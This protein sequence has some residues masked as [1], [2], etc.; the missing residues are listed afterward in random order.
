MGKRKAGNLKIIRAD[1]LI[2]CMRTNQRAHTVLY[3][4]YSN[5]QSGLYETQQLYSWSICRQMPAPLRLMT[6]CVYAIN[7]NRLQRS[8]YEFRR[9][10]VFV[11]SMVWFQNQVG[12]KGKQLD[13]HGLHKY[14]WHMCITFTCKGWKDES[15]CML[16]P[17]WWDNIES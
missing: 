12:I 2:R 13:I 7:I 1:P 5:R 8:L 3:V 14:K 10:K 15:G 6:Y 17:S 16:S 4:L 9:L 11:N